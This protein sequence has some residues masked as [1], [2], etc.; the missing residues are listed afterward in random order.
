[1]KR[2]Q[3][4]FVGGLRLRR[5]VTGMWV[6]AAELLIDLSR[7]GYENWQGNG[8]DQTH[9]PNPAQDKRRSRRGSPW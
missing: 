5:M 3:K 9:L 1:M 4:R 7:F 2:D 8:R 6:D